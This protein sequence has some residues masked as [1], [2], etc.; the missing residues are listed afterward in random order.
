[1]DKLCAEKIK[2]LKG[3]LNSAEKL[4]QTRLTGT[5]KLLRIKISQHYSIFP[6]LYG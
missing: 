3:N 4:T 2:N 6:N 5:D 1:M